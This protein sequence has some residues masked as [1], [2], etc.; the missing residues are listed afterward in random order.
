MINDEYVPSGFFV[1]RT[2]LLPFKT[3]VDWGRQ[4]DEDQANFLASIFRDPT[5]REGLFLASPTLEARLDKWLQNPKADEENIEP[6]LVRYFARMTGRTVPFGLFAGLSIGQIGDQTSIYLEPRDKNRRK[7]SLRSEFVA[8]IIETALQ[9]RSIRDG[10][11]FR[12]NPSL[13]SLGGF[14]RY[15]ERRGGSSLVDHYLSSV[16]ETALLDYVLKSASTGMTLP[17]LVRHLPADSAPQE[18]RERFVEDLASS[19]ILT[20]DLG[21]PT[22][23]DDVLAQPIDDLS[24]SSGAARLHSALKEIQSQLQAIDSINAA[25]SADDYRALESRVLNVLPD[26]NVHK[27]FHVDLIKT[28]RNSCLSKEVVRDALRAVEILYQIAPAPSSAFLRDFVLK[29]NT[30]FENRTVPLLTALDPDFG[31]MVQGTNRASALQS[32]LVLVEQGADTEAPPS[33]GTPGALLR[34]VEQ[35]WC[36]GDHAIDLDEDTLS[37]ISVRNKAPLPDAFSVSLALE[38][39]GDG[40]VDQQGCSLYVRGMYGPSGAEFLGRF[41]HADAE[42]RKLVQHHL[43]AEES[44]Q[45]D[46]IFAEIVHLPSPSVG[47]VVRRPVLRQ[48]ELAYV[49]RSGALDKNQISANDLAVQVN[50][51][52][53]RLYSISQGREVI[54]R[55]TSAHNYNL[56]SLPLY[57]LLCSLR[58]QDAVTGLEWSWGDL[59]NAAFLPRV[60]SA[61]IVLSRARW[62]VSRA[63]VESLLADF[64]PATISKWRHKLKL[65]QFVLLIDGDRELPIDLCC[66]ASVRAMLDWS[67]SFS[68][69]FLVEMFPTPSLSPV[70]SE[71]GQ[72]S[73]EVILPFVKVSHQRKEETGLT[74]STRKAPTPVLVDATT[75]P[76]GSDW[77]YLK[78]YGGAGFLDRILTEKL[79]KQIEELVDASLVKR[80]FF[81]RYMDPLL[82]LR[83]RLSGDKS[84][85]MHEVVPRLLEIAQAEVEHGRAWLVA[86]DTYEPEFEKFGGEAGLATAED[87]FRADSET[88]LAVLNTASTHQS[89]KEFRWRLALLGADRLLECLGYGISGKLQL[90]CNLR[91]GFYNEFSFGT[92]QRRQLSRKFRDLRAELESILAGTSSQFKNLDMSFSCRQPDLVN[93]FKNLM[94]LRAEQSLHKPVDEI[95]LDLIHLRINRLTPSPDPIDE[96]VIYDFLVR[97]YESQVARASARRL[98]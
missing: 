38:K 3:F 29:F 89:D 24:K 31:V 62:R 14:L 67:K 75:F 37:E 20:P 72:F 69:V 70:S 83:V 7:T 55:L 90:I 10:L 18:I 30:R 84:V 28:S 19:Q 81:I 63:N 51:G 57:Q 85:L 2:P 94:S 95:V 27:A 49:G 36:H 33:Q 22:T 4:S 60:T 34:L 77:F 25:Q 98:S 58:T 86:T 92:H 66:L 42:L 12:P 13:Y 8:K 32:G 5:I 56:R 9:S 47:D 41:C 73:H 11:I 35:A 71:E 54:P 53:V 43:E 82:H 79:S 78:V 64:G 52:K 65:P 46:A 15:V 40:E 6:S 74:T 44:A 1:L 80:W 21:V 76:P 16:K 87:M 91:D 93:G 97:L 61:R 68:A 26:A 59:S 17:D 45:P 88:V 96:L 48:F 50:D 39:P 23:C